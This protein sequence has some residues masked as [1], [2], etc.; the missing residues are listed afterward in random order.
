MPALPD[1]P[2]DEIALRLL[3]LANEAAR[4]CNEGEVILARAGLDI[5]DATFPGPTHWLTDKRTSAVM[6]GQVM[7]FF[8]AMA[9]HEELIRNFIAGLEAMP[10]IDRRLAGGG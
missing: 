5:G 6:V 1:L 10:G 4:A 8:K 2:F 7:Q 9:P 3:H